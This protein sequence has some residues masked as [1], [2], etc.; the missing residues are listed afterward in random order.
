MQEMEVH[1]RISECVARK[2]MGSP[3]EGGRSRPPVASRFLCHSQGVVVLV[4]PSRMLV[5]DELSF[6]TLLVAR[7]KALGRGPAGGP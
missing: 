2:E 5:R 3:D 7:C 4:T 6:I 1:V